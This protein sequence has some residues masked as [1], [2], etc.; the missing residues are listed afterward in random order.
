MNCQRVN[1]AGEGGKQMGKELLAIKSLRCSAF[2]RGF[3]SFN[4]RD[5]AF[6]A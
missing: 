4:L 3:P 5:D 1:A 6:A 2:T